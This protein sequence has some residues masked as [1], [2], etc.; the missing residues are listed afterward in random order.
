MQYLWGLINS[1]QMVI[2]MPLLDI[3]FPANANYVFSMLIQIV[4]LDLFPS[5]DALN[6][7]FDFPDD[8]GYNERFNNLDIF[9][10]LVSII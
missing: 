3:N 2:H 1:L 9:S 10:I 7:F 8:S 4:T 5:E 6:Y